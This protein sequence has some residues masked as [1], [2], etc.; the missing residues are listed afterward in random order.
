VQV[1]RRIIF[2]YCGQHNP[3]INGEEQKLTSEPLKILGNYNEHEGAIDFAPFKVY[4]Q[5][6]RVPVVDGHLLS[7]SVKTKEKVSITALID[8]INNFQPLKALTCHQHRKSR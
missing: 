1:I 5:C 6:N 7:V 4:A 2:G 3:H 8:A